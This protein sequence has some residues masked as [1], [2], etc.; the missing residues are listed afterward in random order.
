MKDGLPGARLCVVVDRSAVAA[1]W[2]DGLF[3][4]DVIV[5]EHTDLLA[6]VDDLR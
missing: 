6:L 4:G 5:V 2:V 3:V 1:R